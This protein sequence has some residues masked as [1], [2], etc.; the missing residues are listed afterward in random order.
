M[1]E[2][3]YSA[4]HSNQF[5]VDFSCRHLRRVVLKEGREKVLLDDVSIDFAGGKMTAIIGPSGCGK[6]TLLKALCGIE[7]ADEGDIYIGGS[8]FSGRSM[9]AADQLISYLPQFDELNGCLTVDQE[10]DYIAKLR[11]GT[12][13]DKEEIR[14][15]RDEL[16]EEVGLGSKD[17]RAAKISTLSGGEK[18]RVALVCSLIFRPRIIFMDEPTAPLDPGT[19]LSFMNMVKNIAS[20]RNITVIMVTHDPDALPYMDKVVF[21]APGGKLEYAG[22][23]THFISILN[24]RLTT[25]YQQMGNVSKLEQYIVDGKLQTLKLFYS[26]FADDKENK[27]VLECLELIDKSDEINQVIEDNYDIDKMIDYRRH[28][29]LQF[30]LLL[31]RQFSILFGGGKGNSLLILLPI[32]VGLLIGLVAAG[33]GSD[34]NPE[35]F[36]AYNLTKATM[37]SVAAGSFF[38]GIFDTLSAFSN[39]QKIQVEQLHGMG[40][41]PFALAVFVQYTLVAFFQSV[42]L[43]LIFT[44]VVG[45]PS[46]VLYDSSFDILTTA[47]L[48]CATA[49]TTGMLCSAAFPTPM[50]VAPVIVLLQLVF[51]GI[52]FSLSGAAERLSDFVA[53]KW[54]MDAFGSICDLNNLPYSA[55]SVMYGAVEILHPESQYEATTYNLFKCWFALIGLLLATLLLTVLILEMRRSRMYRGSLY[56]HPF[57]RKPLSFVMR[58]GHWLVNSSPKPIR[59][60]LFA[61]LG[62]FAYFQCQQRG[63]RLDELSH[64]SNLPD[65]LMEVLRSVPDHLANLFDSWM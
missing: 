63:I 44:S 46:I 15:Y 64:L 65:Y 47:F 11:C 54:A 48:C 38:I 26:S 61:L 12:N 18:K 62:A 17:K 56:K 4:K 10:I 32:I 42:V 49:M 23:Y 39:R 40:T 36:E 27:K 60:G 6:S 34:A 33:G 55:P 9:E 2:G 20:S 37:F 16:L 3:P 53:C 14:D 45:T 30:V 52:I 25:A 58:L 21:L 41:C 7:R 28:G 59:F 50:Y 31:K 8:Q 19:T 22:L 29:L 13:I 5:P 35:V 1:T 51:S 57:I 43:Y 24:D